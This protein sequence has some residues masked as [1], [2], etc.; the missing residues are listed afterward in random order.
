[1]RENAERLAE[2][3]CERNWVRAEDKAWCV[4]VLEKWMGILLFFTAVT[5][6]M[7]VSGL[8]VETLGFLVPFYLLRRR[9][10][11]CHARSARACFFISMGLVI[12]V[13]AFLGRQLALLPRGPLMLLDGAV[14][15]AGLLMSPAYPPQL[16]FTEEEKAANGRKK[17]LLLG[18]IFLL[19]LLTAA[20]PACRFPAFSLCGV[21][22]SLITVVIQKKILEK[23]ESNDEKI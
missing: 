3:C 2:L 17:N 20:V 4:Y 5:V 15:V 14:I 16:G 10:G 19:Q 23:G 18:E 21:T 8:W 12:F 22:I 6:W 7:A 9:I 1:M 11:G 13:S